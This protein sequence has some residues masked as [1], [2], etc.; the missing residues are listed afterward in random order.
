MKGKAAH[1]QP[2]KQGAEEIGLGLEQV[3]QGHH[4]QAQPQAPAHPQLGQVE[5]RRLPGP[6]VLAKQAVEGIDEFFIKAQDKGHRPPGHPG[7]AV[8]QG[9]AKTVKH[10]NKHGTFSTF[11][12]GSAVP[13]RAGGGLLSSDE[14]DYTINLQEKGDF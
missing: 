4:R 2:Q 7:D 9:H 3:V 6:V 12:M 10:F 8:G 5:H 14:S 11:S 13:R 1:S